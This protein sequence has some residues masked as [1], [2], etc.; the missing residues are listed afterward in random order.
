M[1]N[2]I[3]WVITR[4]LAVIALIGFIIVGGLFTVYPSMVVGSPITSSSSLWH[5]LTLA[6]MAT[7]SILALLV[8][9]NPRRY[10]DM[11]LPLFIGKI[12]SSLSSL[13]W[14]IQFNEN[15][16]LTN[17]LTDGAIAVM[18]LILY[19]MGKRYR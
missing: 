5:S 19:L 10:L 2:R 12:V 6:F 1:R 7:V 9:I 18:A 15:I 11:L 17:T 3:F 16:L 13:Y 8:A 14:Y 4:I